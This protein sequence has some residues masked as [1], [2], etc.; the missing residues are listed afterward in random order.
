MQPPLYIISS[1][2]VAKAKKVAAAMKNGVKSKCCKKVRTIPRFRRPKTLK[3]PKKIVVIPKEIQ[4]RNKFDDFRILKTP[5]TSEAAL[6]KVEMHNTVVFT[7]D[8]K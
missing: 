6:K 5:I 4:K 1:A 3:T 7:C 8:V 2:E